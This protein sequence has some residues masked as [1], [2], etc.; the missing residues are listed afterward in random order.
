MRY[1]IS[2]SCLL[3][4]FVPSGVGDSRLGRPARR[5]GTCAGT[6]SRQHV[7]AA[8]S[9]AR[10]DVLCSRI[11]DSCSGSYNQ[12]STEDS[13]AGECYQSRRTSRRG[14]V[15]LSLSD[16]TGHTPQHHKQQQ[17]DSCRLVPFKIRTSPPRLPERP[18]RRLT[19][20]KLHFQWSVC[21]LPK[22]LIVRGPPSKGK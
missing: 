16:S 12:V 8:R 6:Q 19:K 3:R 11:L 20:S 17:Q 9:R 7:S 1:A 5:T 4:S 22:L 21:R 15:R 14:A 2:V 13:Q 10:P 18:V